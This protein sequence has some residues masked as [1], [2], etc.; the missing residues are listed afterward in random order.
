[1]HVVIV[2]GGW[3]GLAAA[4]ELCQH[5]ARVTVLEAAPQLGGRA[6]GLDSTLNGQRIDN[7]QHLLLGA[8]RETLRLLNILG[9]PEASVFERRPLQLVYKAFRHPDIRITCPSLP[10]PLHLVTALLN[11]EGLTLAER[12]NALSICRGL[13][14]SG[15]KID[16]DISVAAWLSHHKQ[17]P[18]LIRALWEP[19]CLAVL[20]TPLHNA[21]VQVFL[22]VLQDAF[23]RSRSDSDLLLSR[24][25]LGNT[26]PE[27]A[28]RFIE[29]HGGTVKL[30][31]RAKG[32]TV[33]NNAVRN[34][35]VNDYGIA[36]DH[37]ILAIPPNACQRL[38]EPHTV[39]HGIAQR[40]G[41]ISHEPICTVYIQYPPQ[42]RLEMPMI[43]LLDTTT[44][45]V[46]DRALY[47]QPGLMAAV[48]SG[49]GPHMAMSKSEL[50][51]HVASEL[52]RVF[53]HWATSEHGP[54]HSLVIR[55]KYAT[56]ACRP[57][58]NTLRPG[59]ATPVRGCWLAGDHTDTGYP[60]TLEGAVRSGVECARL[61]IADG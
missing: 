50:S 4:V 36:A 42:T 54:K 60:A 40:L 10:A 57:G 49:P 33:Q 24:V 61:I 21:S 27:P 18:A 6:R 22:R 28:R 5:G 32:L 39:L 38:M 56:F 17:S 26:F 53:P 31:H 59:A 9:V 19:L 46:F 12:L 52:A 43:G 23:T 35:S 58:I 11:A 45:W 13:L 41:E 48:I 2:G 16:D 7:G 44:Q 37:V 20:N 1:M 34:V 55:E 15:F 30:S 25:D 14:R 51:A 29:Q 8:Y 3:A 47:G